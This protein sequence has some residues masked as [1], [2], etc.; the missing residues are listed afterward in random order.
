MSSA[1]G[2]KATF[3]MLVPCFSRSRIGQLFGLT[4]I[5][6]D[7]RYRLLWRQCSQSTLS[8]TVRCDGIYASQGFYQKNDEGFEWIPDVV[9]ATQTLINL[10]QVQ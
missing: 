2:L 9:S 8:W 5:Q 10:S 3:K 1:D 6:A 4:Q 7:L